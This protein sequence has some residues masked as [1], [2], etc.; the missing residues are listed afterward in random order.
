MSPG[1]VG[2]RDEVLAVLQGRAEDVGLERA[3][4]LEWVPGFLRR[5]TLECRAG[6]DAEPEVLARSASF[7]C[8]H[9]SLPMACGGSTSST[10]HLPWYRDR[11]TRRLCVLHEL[12][13]GVGKRFGVTACEAD[14]WV[15]TAGAVHLAVVQGRELWWPTWFVGA[16]PRALV[17]ALGAEREP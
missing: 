16:I 13:H 9:A 4:A 17:I 6:F 10:L 3:G 14:W 5:V 7:R 2:L 11:P 8:V 1:C 12:L 15:C